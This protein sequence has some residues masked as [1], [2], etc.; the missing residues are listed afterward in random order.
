MRY[1][2]PIILSQVERGVLKGSFQA[3]V[4]M[5]DIVDFTRIAES[6][7][8]TQFHG[9]DNIGELLNKITAGPIQSVHKYGGFISHFVGDAICAIFIGEDPTAMLAALMEIRDFLKDF[10]LICIEGRHQ[11]VTMREIISY[12]EVKWTVFSNPYQY[13]YLFYGEAFSELSLLCEHSCKN[14]YSG[15]VITKIGAKHFQED[16]AC[17]NLGSVFLPAKEQHHKFSFSPH[18]RSVFYHKNFYDAKLNNE[19]R[20]LAVCFVRIS[21]ATTNASAIHKLH[22]VADR[23][24]GYVNKIDCA[25]S[26]PV[27][28]V[29][30]GVP[31]SEGKS[32]YQACEFARELALRQKNLSIG[33]SCGY[34]FA[35]LIGSPDV[36]EYTAL[37]QCLNLASRLAKQAKPGEIIMDESVY[38]ETAKMYDTK[39]MGSLHLKGISA[40]IQYY[41]LSLKRI[42]RSLIFDSIFV[43]RK[44]EM[45]FLEELRT[46]SR[47]LHR[48]TIVY[49]NGD[50]GLGKSRLAWEYMQNIDGHYKFVVTNDKL[51]NG[52]L[53]A[54]RQILRAIFELGE[55]D[56]EEQT[57]SILDE[58]FK[59][60]DGEMP[61]HSK[62]FLAAI[63]ELWY[64]G[65]AWDHCPLEQRQERQKEAFCAIIS[66]L[67]KR[68]PVLLLLDD[69]QWIDET[70][71]Q[72]LAALD[73]CQ[74]HNLLI[75]CPSRYI[76]GGNCVDLHLDKFTR[77][78]LNLAPL[79]PRDCRSMLTSILEIKNSRYPAIS[80]IMN[81]ADGFPLY[82]EQMA[83][84]LLE[85]GRKSK[86]PL[87][88]PEKFNSFSISDVMNSR[89]DGFNQGMRE[90]LYYAS[91]LGMSFN[92]KL[93]T[94]VLDK[95]IRPYL[96][97]GYSHRLWKASAPGHYSFS[98]VILR[99]IVYER[100]LSNTVK[101][102]HR[103]VA[104]TLARQLGD[105]DNSLASEAAYH[106]E[107]ADCAHEAQ[108]F[109]QRASKYHMK[110]SRWDI[111]ISY[112]RKAT[113][114]SG[115][116]FGFGSVEHTENLFW[117]AIQYHY[118]QY[119]HKAV[120]LY[121]IVL[122]YKRKHL[123]EDDE[124]MSPYLNNLGRCFKDISRFDEAEILL[125][126]SLMIEYRN[127][128]YS[129]NVA[130][131]LNN[132]A[133]LYMKQG[134]WRKALA[135]ARK[136]AEL[137]RN[138]PHR[139]QDYFIGMME[140]NIGYLLLRM[141]AYNEAEQKAIQALRYFRTDC[142]P[143]NPRVAGA[144]LLMGQC[145]ALRKEYNKAEKK[146]LLARSKYGRFFGKNSPDY[147]KTNLN[148]GDLYEMMGDIDKAER[149]WKKGARLLLKLMPEGLILAREA[150]VRLQKIETRHQQTKSA[151]GRKA[152]V[153][154]QNSEN[155]A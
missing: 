138:T 136:A 112:Q 131:R 70:S 134:K 42:K 124:L 155:S 45:A 8:N 52:H 13:E 135:Y 59:E 71:R 97:L 111:G 57:K 152:T 149:F 69:G 142:G 130:D 132:L 78:D 6:F 98:H 95:D 123:S 17:A 102:M 66:Y 62:A 145:M 92:I 3:F 96:R 105:N 53:D 143:T 106:Y 133:S 48:N 93:L 28:L 31:R 100:L 29:L 74:D 25:E 7:Q 24:R 12:G 56:D 55:D 104:D 146:L 140:S 153:P 35:G 2:P 150:K 30:F 23:Y 148:L 81:K 33:L 88:L 128:K 34:A 137:F 27:A 127:D 22:I 82:L 54:V 1:V 67:L 89:I 87:Q 73:P 117:L 44:E 32:A 21:S 113:T 90:C 144:H 141:G 63:L 9:A 120:K 77:Y 99:D 83:Y 46:T 26:L 108:E 80:T 18:T 154:A 151:G 47:K 4:M 40:K 94:K 84:Y 107:K 15:S 121:N 68:K 86:H 79:K 64:K 39:M 115:R 101:K 14:A 11:K 85:R 5:L 51:N 103:H 58:A 65:S 10:P 110:M 147:A 125:R 16:G 109:L 118:I 76:A 38:R 139:E 41:S 61:E 75:L 72:F 60:I 20:N 119:Y 37:G 114:M 50:P 129:T 126:K 49:I 116:H 19:I 43:G 91:I 36:Q 122:N